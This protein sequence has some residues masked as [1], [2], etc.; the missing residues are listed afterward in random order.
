MGLYFSS[1]VVLQ[2]DDTIPQTVWLKIGIIRKRDFL[3]TAI[4]WNGICIR[5]FFYALR[6]RLWHIRE[7]VI[8]Q[9]L[10]E[11]MRT[12]E[13]IVT[14]WR[15]THRYACRRIEILRVFRPTVGGRK[16]SHETTSSLELC[17]CV[18]YHSLLFGR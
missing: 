18:S 11:V 2:T 13:R 14:R 8:V 10:I 16:D 5:G 12:V 9:Q 7:E 3:L 17:W 4:A 15:T 6:R 1:S